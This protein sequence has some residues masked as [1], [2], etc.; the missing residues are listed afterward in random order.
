MVA[1]T[2]LPRDIHTFPSIASP[3]RAP[4]NLGRALHS[5]TRAKPPAQAGSGGRKSFLTGRVI[6]CQ[7][8]VPAPGISQ[9]KPQLLRSSQHCRARLFLPSLPVARTQTH[10]FSSLL[11]FSPLP[12]RGLEVAEKNPHGK[13][14]KGGWDPE[15]ES[16]RS[17]RGRNVQL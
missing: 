14:W 11:L 3:G 8:H 1:Y 16:G 17:E 6:R 12:S 13:A 4:C 15:C 9:H 5:L 7:G 10:P 2:S